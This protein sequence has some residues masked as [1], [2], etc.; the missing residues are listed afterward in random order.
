MAQING[1][2]QF[3]EGADGVSGILTVRVEQVA[4]MDSPAEIV[5]QMQTQI[6]YTGHAIPF[7]LETPEG[8]GPYNLRAILSV[9]GTP[10]DW[11]K[12][13]YVTM[14]AYPLGDG[15]TLQLEAI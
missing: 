14:S 6:T 8:D 11:E 15:L 3:P 1:I 9:N 5:Q 10:D 4:M 13:D 7:S 2:V 12:G